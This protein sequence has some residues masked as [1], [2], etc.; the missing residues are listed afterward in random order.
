MKMRNVGK[1]A[2]YAK[3]PKNTYMLL[4]PIKGT[5]RAIFMRGLKSYATKANGARLGA[6]VAVP[7]AIA[8]L[9]GLVRR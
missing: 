6:V 1:L 7:L 2:A 8:A 4:H 5:K 9:R 3:S